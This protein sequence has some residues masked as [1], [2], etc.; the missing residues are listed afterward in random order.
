MMGTFIRMNGIAIA[1]S[2]VFS[3]NSFASTDNTIN[4]RTI[5]DDPGNSQYDRLQSA[6]QRLYEIQRNGGWHKI[7][8]TQKYYLKG[9]TSPAISQI[10]ERLRISGDFN[11]NDTSD[12]FTD[13]LVSAIQNVQKRF[14]FKR[15]GVVDAVLLKELNV[16][17]EERIQQLQL[18]I[19]RFKNAETDD[20]QT[21]LVVNIPEYKL[22][23]YEGTEQVFD[24][25]IVVGSEEHKT[26]TFD[27]EMTNIVFSPYW[28]VPP[29]IVENEILPAMQRNKNYLRNNNYEITGYEDGLP[30]IR[31]KPGPGNSLGQVKFVFPNEHGIYFHDTPAKSLFQYPKRTFSHGCIRLANPAKLAAYLLRN[32]PRWTEEKIKA[33][34]NSGKEQSVMLPHKIPVSLT[35]Y[36]AWVDD[37]GQLQLREDIY[38][39]DRQATLTGVASR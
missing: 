24:M 20:G 16:P 39:L 15:N 35:Y 38:G 23:V 21:R 19:Q 7:N 17:V 9:Q 37:Q 10:K 26:V 6:L 22:H 3:A 33:A 36:T 5:K 29:S 28:N 13:D 25:D 32:S 27:D 11:S 12:L 18:N 2:I 14:G 1:I 4:E 8:G 34:M 31:Q 30:V